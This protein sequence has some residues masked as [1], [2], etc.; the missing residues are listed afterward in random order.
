M[1]QN[2]RNIIP[3]DYQYPLASVMYKIIEKGNSTYSRWLHETGISDGNKKFKYFTFSR[4][5]PQKY[6]VDGDKMIIINSKT[7]FFASFYIDNHAEPFIMGLFKDTE[8]ELGNALYRSNF[9]ISSVEKLKDFDFRDR[10]S[11]RCLSPIVVS[12][13]PDSK[14]YPDYLKPDD[15]R[16]AELLI[17]NLLQKQQLFYDRAEIPILETLIRNCNFKI[18]GDYKKKGVTI[19]KGEPGETKIIGYDFHFSIVLPEAMQRIGYY[20]GFGEK[21][22]MGFGCVESV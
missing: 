20:A 15:K 1:N 14:K 17:K 10:M 8:I 18:W 13:K 19:K 12:Y 6:K 2:A 4:L 21:N 11:F 9:R 22:S 16:F 5:K 7:E 3:I